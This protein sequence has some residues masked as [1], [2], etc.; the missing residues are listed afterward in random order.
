MRPRDLGWLL[1]TEWAAPP[2][3]PP[4]TEAE[5]LGLPPF[6]RAVS[7]VTNAVASTAWHAQRWDG[8]LGVDVKLPDQPSVLTDPYPNVTPWHYRWAAAEDLVLYGNHFALYGD[9]DFRTGRPGWVAP[10]PSEDVW[11]LADPSRPWDYRW[12]IGGAVFDPDEILHVSSGARSGEL[13]GRGVIAQY[14]AWLGGAVAAEDHASS[15]FSGGA[16][17][18]AVITADQVVTQDQATELKAKWRTLT[19]TREPVILPRG[20]TLTPVVSGAVQAQLVESRQW[21]A[22][23]AANVVGVPGWKLGLPGPTMT[24]QNVET[25]DIDFIRDSVDRYARPLSES[26]TKWLMPRGTS[27]VWD[28]ASRMR[29][30][31]TTTADVVTKYKTAGIITDDEARAV[32]GRPPMTATD[33]TG[34]TPAGVPELTPSTVNT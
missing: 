3:A 9:L 29:A 16:L 11:I 20:V 19:S 25:A 4:A 22:Q 34:S 2:T 17:P 28:Y 8:D 15:Y 18:P 23:M 26:F 21:N 14:G 33:K 7:L 30:D 32:I 24:Y 13:L 1:G 31:Q 12:V 10:V 6:G 27:V 5:A